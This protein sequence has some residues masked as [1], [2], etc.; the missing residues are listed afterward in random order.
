MTGG[1]GRNS[2]HLEWTQTIVRADL[3]LSQSIKMDEGNSPNNTNPINQECRKRLGQRL[4]MGMGMA[5]SAAKSEHRFTFNH[6]PTVAYQLSGACHMDQVLK[7]ILQS[8]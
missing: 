6:V 1:Q 7:Q 8:I 2:L 3:E 5:Y 4:G